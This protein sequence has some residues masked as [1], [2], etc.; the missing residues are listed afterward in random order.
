MEMEPV[1]FYS[2]SQMN[3]GD[4]EDEMMELEWRKNVC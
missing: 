3:N 4:K 2:A 1:K